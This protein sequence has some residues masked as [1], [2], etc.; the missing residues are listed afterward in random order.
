MILC[1]GEDYEQ[2]DDTFNKWSMLLPAICDCT[3]DYSAIFPLFFIC[4]E[5]VFILVYRRQA[6]S[7]MYVGLTMTYASVFQ[8][9]R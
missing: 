3:V 8:M 2:A 1:K 6:T 9:L 5:H 4:F 7:L